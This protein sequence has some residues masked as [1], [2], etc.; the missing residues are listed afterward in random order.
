MIVGR[1]SSTISVNT[2]YQVSCTTV[3]PRRWPSLAAIACH[4]VLN[5]NTKMTSSNPRVSR[6]TG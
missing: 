6:A 1:A 3:S 4:R 5:T 2:R